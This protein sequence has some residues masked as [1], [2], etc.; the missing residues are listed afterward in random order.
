MS[1]WRR[2]ISICSD[3]A[4]LQRGAKYYVN[5]CMACH[6]LSHMRYSRMADDLGID[7][8]SLRENLLFGDA[9]PTDMMKNSMRPADGEV[10]F[11]TAVPDLTLVTR[12]RSPDW[13]YTYLKSFYADPTRPYG[14]NNV[15]FPLVG[16]PH[17]LGDLQGMQEAIVEE[18]EG[19]E[20]TI[21]G[22]KLAQ[23][24]SSGPRGIRQHGARHHRVP[25]LCGRAEPDWSGAGWVS[26]SCCSS[27]SSSSWPLR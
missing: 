7:D 22:V 24:G 9:Q 8:K 27:V 3:Q 19:H 10:W 17:V 4:S 21:A 6:S 23:P 14:V 15:I 11:G 25:H 18:H 20:P 5:Y 13:V 12:W 2:P 16:M 1:S 26:M